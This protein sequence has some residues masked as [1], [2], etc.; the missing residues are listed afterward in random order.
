MFTTWK[1]NVRLSKI[2]Y[3]G[4]RLEEQL[5]T[6]NPH[7]RDSLLRLRSLCCNLT[8]QSPL[9]MIEDS[10]TYTLQNF[11]ERQADYRGTVEHRL[12][13]FSDD[14][15]SLVRVACDEVI[16][17]FLSANKIIPDRKMNFMER[18]ALRTEC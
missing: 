15:R 12:R 14:V 9:F 4:K 16:D 7:M 17:R 5:F 11:Q 13:V 1:R 10:T 6:L 3:T 18:A 2:K 8:E